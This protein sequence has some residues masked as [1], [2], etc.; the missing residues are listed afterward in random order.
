MGAPAP[1]KSRDPLEFLQLKSKV[2]D[3]LSSFHTSQQKSLLSLLIWAFNQER[4]SEQL[5]LELISIFFFLWI[6]MMLNQTPAFPSSDP[7]CWLRIRSDQKT[8][9]WGSSHQYSCLWVL[10]SSF[11]GK[12]KDCV[13]LGSFP[14]SICKLMISHF[15]S[16]FPSVFSRLFNYKYIITNSSNVRLASRFHLQDENYLSFLLAVL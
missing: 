8:L 14:H 13:L 15:L 2:S 7:D 10:F 4:N 16:F 11:W 12:I 9:A 3:S 6:L 1:P 5:T